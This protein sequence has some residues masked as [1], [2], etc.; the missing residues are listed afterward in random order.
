MA[1]LRGLLIDN[2]AEIGSIYTNIAATANA[3]PSKTIST[4]VA[5]QFSVQIKAPGTAVQL[6]N[7]ASA[8]TS[9]SSVSITSV[10][11]VL[12]Q[13]LTS[14]ITYPTGKDLI[15]RLRIQPNSGSR[16]DNYFT[17]PVNTTSLT[18]SFS[19]DLAVNDR[20]FVDVTQIGSI[21]PGLGLTV[22]VRYI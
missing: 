17:I 7:S 6:F 18:Q 4:G 12:L 8:W 22:Y 13:K 19:Y 11:A 20:V 10:Y 9:P 14:D 3:T 15:F 16:T 2:S 21:R 5:K 1:R